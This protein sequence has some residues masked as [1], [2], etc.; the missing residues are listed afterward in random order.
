MKCFKPF[1]FCTFFLLC[2]KLLCKQDCP[3]KPAVCVLDNCITSFEI[4]P[5]TWTT[6]LMAGLFTKYGAIFDLSALDLCTF[7]SI[8][9]SCQGRMQHKLNSSKEGKGLGKI[10]CQN[11]FYKYSFWPTISKRNQSSFKLKKKNPTVQ[12][13]HS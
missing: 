4:I 8:N 12:K 10:I 13:Y 9:L 1:G 5:A 11:K 6:N 7:S 2:L 3:G